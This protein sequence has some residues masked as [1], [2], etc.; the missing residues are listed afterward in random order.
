MPFITLVMPPLLF[1][2]RHWKLAALGL[3]L[4]GLVLLLPQCGGP[5][6][7]VSRR[8]ARAALTARGRALAQARSDSSRA[9]TYAER[10]ARAYAVARTYEDSATYYHTR[11]DALLPDDTTTVLREFDRFFAD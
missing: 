4:V 11:P 2:I 5:R 1:L 7:A 10:A 8:Q 9:A 6:P 3:V